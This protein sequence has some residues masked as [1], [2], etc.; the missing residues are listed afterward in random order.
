MLGTINGQP[1][2]AEYL[3]L[4]IHVPGALSANLT[5]YWKAPFDLVLEHISAVTSNNS[6]A[7]LKIGD[8]G[9]DDEILAAVAIGDS[10]TPAEFVA[11]NWA[12]TNPTAR[13]T[14]GDVVVFTLDFDGAAG[15]A[16][17]NPTIIALFRRV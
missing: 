5:L 7:T 11:A 3:P 9:D 10:G 16:A 2:A 1:A 14:K 15:T 12:V 4:C 13:I 8:S 6:D 17:Q